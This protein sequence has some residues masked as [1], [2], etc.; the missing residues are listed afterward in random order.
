MNLLAGDVGGTKTS[1]AIYALGRGV[2]D[3]LAVRT[4]RSADY[5]DLESAV[6]AFLADTGL[7]VSRASIG[8]AGPVVD[9][10][11]TAT[12]LPWQVS[13]AGFQ[14]RLGLESFCLLNDLEAIAYAIPVLTADDLVTLNEGYPEAQGTVAILAPG[15]G[16]GEGYLTW[17]GTGW[18]ALP[19]E[20]GHG[21]FAPNGPLQQKLLAYMSERVGHV[22]WE[23]VC[24]GLGMA[25]LYAFC[26]DERL[27]PEPDWLRSKVAAADDPTPV[28]VAHATDSAA[29]EPLC[30]AA[31]ELFLA[32]LGA[33]AGNMYLRLLSP[34]GVYLAGGIPPRIVDELRRPSFLEAFLAK[35]RLSHVVARAP[36]RIVMRPDVGLLGAAAYGQSHWEA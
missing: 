7:R 10:V 34:G 25:N 24:S 27:A 33:E 4:V 31:L 23:R 6:L 22:S 12:N 15:T 5:P 17:T 18:K 32:I 29:P 21:D 2:H 1:L 3:P 9:G 13:I 8:V 35:G 36:L 16:L 30:R 19:S 26:R 14:Q 28:I 20:G 11:T